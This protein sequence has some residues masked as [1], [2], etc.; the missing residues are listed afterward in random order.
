MMTGHETGF[1]IAAANNITV[2]GNNGDIVSVTLFV[3]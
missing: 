1:V 2:A 3:S